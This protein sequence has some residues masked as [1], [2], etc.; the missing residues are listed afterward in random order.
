M[1]N[2][3]KCNSSFKCDICMLSKQH[4]LPFNESSFHAKS[5]FDLIHVDV[6]G[7][8][9]HPT[10]D[11]CRY[12]LT[13]VDDY[14]RAVWVHLM[15][16][17]QHTVSHLKAFHK[18]VQTQYNTN[19]KVIR[20]DNGSEF[21]NASLREY[22]TNH[23]ITHQTSCPYTP[24]Q[25]S[26]VE[27]KHKQ[28]LEIARALKFQ[29]NLPM[30]LWG[31]CILTAA[32]LIN[33][34]PSKALQNKSPYEM[35]HNKPPTL[36]HLRTIGCR[37]YVHNHTTDKFHPRSIPTILIGYPLNQKGYLLYDSLTHKIITSKHVQFDETQFPFHKPSPS[38]TLSSNPTPV[39]TDPF[40]IPTFSI[41]SPISSTSPSYE[42]SAATPITPTSSST[43]N[44]TAPNNNH[45]TEEQSSSTHITEDQSTQPTSTTPSSPIPPIPP[46]PPRTSTRNRTLPTKLKDFHHNLPTTKLN[47]VSKH[48]Y[49]NFIN[50]TNVTSPHHRHL[51]HN[52]N[53]YIEPKTYKQASTNPK[54]KDAMNK[55]I[56]ALEENGTWTIITLPANKVSIDSKWVYRI[57]YF[58]DGSIENTRQGWW[59]KVSHRK[60][61][62]TTKILL[63][64]L[65]RW[66]Q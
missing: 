32:Y 51:I 23:G 57:K 22:L 40:T 8:Y 41:P 3:I 21:L 1:S 45:T 9:R 7:P 56:H 12:F 16:S 33:R 46:P 26:R 47:C 38:D 5:L 35:I 61:A 34:L 28:P 15:P 43:T 11:K 13:I 63:H 19:I 27:R 55:E 64:Q 48:H 18:H 54:W 53:R 52:I 29:A 30:H 2:V 50:Y 25:N 24:K 65:Q 49:T 17:K 44:H 39:M 14:S 62:L 66:S 42:P 31:C 59:Q 58:A 20:S 4:A 36:D 60:R 6:W 37:A 10:I